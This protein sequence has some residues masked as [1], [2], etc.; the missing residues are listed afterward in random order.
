MFTGIRRVA[1]LGG[2]FLLVVAWSGRP[3]GGQSTKDSEGPA[4]TVAF[5]SGAAFMGNFFQAPEGSPQ[6]DVFVGTGLVRLDYPVAGPALALRAG[7]G[8]DIYESFDPS[9]H[10]FL[11]GRWNQ[12]VHSLDGDA[13]FRTRSPRGDVGDAVG[14]ADVLLGSMSYTIRPVRSFHIE[15]LTEM[16]RQVYETS[17]QRNNQGLRAGGAVRFYGFGYVFSPEI[18]ASIGSRDVDSDEEDY[19]EQTL[20]VTVRSVPVPTLYLSLRYRARSRSYST[21]LEGSSNFRR[22]D[23]RGDLTLTT[24][25]SIGA[26][27][28]WTVYVSVQDA[29]STKASRRFD[30]QYLWSG[31][32]YTIG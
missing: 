30:S 11:G 12:G 1:L 22:E 26:R 7:L 29:E 28:S 25:L 20:W 8:G 15:A 4:P 6:K 19:H 18:G 3:A 14:W 13:S 9:F 5:R 16:D 21:H 10:V 27:W 23:E 32:T 24:E 17:T 2:V 31:L